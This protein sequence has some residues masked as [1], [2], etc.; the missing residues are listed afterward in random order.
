M[1]LDAVGVAVLSK[2][3]NDKIG[4][5][6]IEKVNMPNKDTVV[7]VLKPRNEKQAQSLL[8]S[9][10]PSSSRV[11]FT[12][13]RY[14]N[15]LSAHSF[16]MHLRKHING[17]VVSSVDAVPYERIIKF[18]IASCDELG[19]KRNFTL[20]A[21][22]I[23]R[24]SNLILTDENDIITDAIKR[25]TIDTFSARAVV[26]GMSYSPPPQQED[27]ISPADE[28]AVLMLFENFTGG[29]L[30]DYLLK[31]LYGY[32]PA[33]LRQA[34]Y[35]FF[36]SLLPSAEEVKNKKAEF[37]KSLTNFG[38]IYS[39]CC[40]LIDNQAKD[41]F[42]KPYTHLD[43]E[44]KFYPSLSEA[45]DA[46]YSEKEE[47]GF[48][49]G[50]TATLVSVLKSAIK[51]NERSL[52]LLREKI[53]QS[54][55]FEED[56]I[57]GEL[58]TANIYRLKKGASSIEVDDYYTGEKR[59][60][61]LDSTLS[62]QQN[63]QR[64]YKAYT[65]KRRAIEHSEQQLSLSLERGEYLESILTMLE[66][67]ASSSEISEIETEMVSCGLIKKPKVKRTQKPSS[68]LSLTVK[69]YKVLI[70]K[71][72]IQNDKLV[73]SSD[74]G[75][76]WLHAQKIHGSHAVIQATSVPQEVI[77]EVASFVAHFSKASLSSNVPVDYTLVKFVKKPSGAPYGKV[78]YTHQQTVN[79][80]PKKPY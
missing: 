2:E 19:Y 79:V 24:F 46:F 31:N 47:H 23:G 55:D 6:R 61:D 37:Y 65:K 68:P 74:G 36:G 29:K 58:L 69:G 4:G 52:S 75:W 70:G 71:N 7:L 80:T 22:L 67:V 60:I 63:A 34:V 17:G 38:A 53:T 64:F 21:E 20:I 76:L 12:T 1:G 44:F 27:K 25:V 18:S 51:K 57:C 72:N 32:S 9:T 28:Q 26:S 15:P 3:L 59:T 8:L 66:K 73:R 39:P 78:V 56:K 45:M 43:G 41:F 77:N 16:L 50:R 33:S 40:L 30:P 13:K 5:C 48:V 35:E 11:H 14:E 10:L 62:P 42:F 49:T 54:M